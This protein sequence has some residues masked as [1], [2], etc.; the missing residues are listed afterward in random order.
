MLLTRRRDTSNTE[1]SCLNLAGLLM[2]NA[3]NL[4]AMRFLW[5]WKKS[6]DWLSEWVPVRV[7]QALLLLVQV[8]ALCELKGGSHGASG[9]SAKVPMSPCHNCGRGV[10]QK[11][12]L[13]SD[14]R[15]GGFSADSYGASRCRG[16]L[17]ILKSLIKSL[18]TIAPPDAVAL[19]LILH[20]LRS[21]KGIYAKL[22]FTS[23]TWTGARWG[24][25][26][27]VG[28]NNSVSTHVPTAF[29][30]LPPSESSA[31]VLALP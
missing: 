8:C 6:C 22:L 15:E 26:S 27:Q 5:N 31:C 16:P 20:L 7:C 17:P 12:R 21:W 14:H 11:A 3:A 1:P 4:A 30:A 10:T 18:V 23:D 2:R 13:G 19:I 28:V 24:L 29:P 25:C 9:Q